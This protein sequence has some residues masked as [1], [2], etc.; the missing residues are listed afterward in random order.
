MGDAELITTKE[1]F[2]IAVKIDG[3]LND[4]VIF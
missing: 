1:I 3:N 2:R 4:T